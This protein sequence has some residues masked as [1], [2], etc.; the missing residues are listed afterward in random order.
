[1]IPLNRFLL[2][3]VI[4]EEEEKQT[5]FYLPEDVVVTSK[6]PH[7]VVEVVDVSTESKFYDKLL[8]GDKIV[9][10]GHMLTKV[11]LFGETAHLIEDNYILGKC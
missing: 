7:E 9:V 4:E 5:A 2:V 3:N 1:M 6:K 10:E 11:D 8:T